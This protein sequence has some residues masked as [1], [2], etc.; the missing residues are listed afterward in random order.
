MSR[1]GARV[2]V[3]LSVIAEATFFSFQRRERRSAVRYVA[4][5][6]TKGTRL[7]GANTDA[8]AVRSSFDSV[9]VR[10]PTCKGGASGVAWGM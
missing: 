6:R 9:T 1:K 8:D 3:P 10:T 4:A 7:F 5:T 2:I